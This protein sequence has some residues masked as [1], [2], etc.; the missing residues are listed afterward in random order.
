VLE[1]FRRLS[2]VYDLGSHQHYNAMQES[3]EKFDT[4]IRKGVT[5]APPLPADFG[6]RVWRS[7]P[8]SGRENLV[9]RWLEGT[10]L[11]SVSPKRFVVSYCISAVF[12]SG[13]LGGVLGSVVGSSKKTEELFPSLQSPPKLTPFDD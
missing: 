2:Y 9:G 13:I 7:I 8:E 3:A 11:S 1:R 10:I 5:I 12:I 4:I 6:D